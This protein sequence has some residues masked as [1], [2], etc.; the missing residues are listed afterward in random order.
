[1]WT[2]HLITTK[3]QQYHYLICKQKIMGNHKMRLK[4]YVWENKNVDDLCLR[5]W[6]IVLWLKKFFSQQNSNHLRLRIGGWPRCLLLIK[7]KLT[8]PKTKLLFKQKT[9]QHKEKSYLNQVNNTIRTTYVVKH[10][11][12]LCYNIKL[13]SRNYTVL[14]KALQHS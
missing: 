14:L 8:E 12:I 5:Q 1:M 10:W 13:K 11:I 9:I 4:I 3:Y 2:V 6:C 7:Q